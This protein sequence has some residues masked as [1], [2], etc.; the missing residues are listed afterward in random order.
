MNNSKSQT[1]LTKTLIMFTVPLILSGVL[2]QLYNWVDAFIVGNV[3]GEA[4]L[5]AN[6]VTANISN[7]LIMMIVGFSSGISVLA[8][9]YFGDNNMKIQHKILSSFASLMFVIFGIVAMLGIIFASDLLRLLNT[10]DDIFLYAKQYLQIIL[11]GVPFLS[12]YNVYSAVLRGVGNSKVPLYAILISS[13]INIVLDVIFVIVFSWGIQGAAIATLIAQLSMTVFI[14]F[15]STK[16]Y[17]FLQFALNKNIL[18]FS[19]LKKGFNLSFPIMT[20]SMISSFGNL[21]LLNFLNG[22]G[23][24][25]VIA[26]TTAYRI[27]SIIMLPLINIGTGI[28]T[29]TA[30]N[31]GA[32]NHKRARQTLTSGTILSICISILL[33]LFVLQFGE[34][35][36]GI[37]GVTKAVAVLG[38][39]FFGAIAWFYVIYGLAMAFRGYLVGIEDVVFSGICSIFALVIRIGLSYALLP[40]IGN[41]TI[42]YAEAFSWVI[43]LILFL[44]RVYNKNKK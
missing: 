8:S 6:G 30:Q 3:L 43:L 34:E 20:Q 39:E 37:F 36:I 18:D 1:N 29:I 22:L 12:I 33:M 41:M 40:I 14:V 28:S 44:I 19:V 13:I 27:D 5:A 4:A 17:S 11:I 26:I 42:A 10:P 38:G 25:M 7:M 32:G 21:I 16:K 15:Y 24:S 2:Q 35:L 9:L 31:K 23:T